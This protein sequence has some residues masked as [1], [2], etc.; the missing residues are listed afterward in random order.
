MR[1]IPTSKNKT[2][3]FL[4]PPL[5]P[6]TQYTNTPSPQFIQRKQIIDITDAYLRI[7]SAW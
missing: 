3:L 6:G 7:L 5:K 4:V 1:V 2:F